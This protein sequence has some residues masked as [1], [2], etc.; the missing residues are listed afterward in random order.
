MINGQRNVSLVIDWH[1]PYMAIV[2]PARNV[3]VHTYLL[4][5][6]DLHKLKKEDQTGRHSGYT[7]THSA[8]TRGSEWEKVEFRH[9]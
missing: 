2:Q 9:Y 4:A 8:N 5:P 6:G 1:W 7:H 3:C